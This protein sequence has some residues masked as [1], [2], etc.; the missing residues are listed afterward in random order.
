MWETLVTVWD[1]SQLDHAYSTRRAYRR[2]QGTIQ[3]ARPKIVT[4]PASQ[5]GI[6]T[7]MTRSEPGSTLEIH[8]LG[9]V[10]VLIDGRPLVVD[11]RKALAILVLL[12]V[13]ARPFARE[14]LA[15]LLWPESD[16]ESARGAL[17][18]TLSVLRA[19]LGGRWLA[20]DRSVV[21][22]N[23]GAGVDLRT[24]VAATPSGDAAALARAAGLA[25]GPFLAGF[26]LRDSAEFD[27]WRAAQAVAAE[28]AV[29]ALLDRLAAVAEAD[30]DLAGAAAAARR[31]VDLDP[32]DEPAQRRLISVL[33]RS[34]D[35]AGAIRQYRACVAL[36]ERELGVAPLPDTTQ[37]YEAIRDGRVGVAS[38][39]AAP[40]LGPESPDV[41]VDR[42]VAAVRQPSAPPV[43]ARLPMIGRDA[44]LASVLAAHRAATH[45]GRIVLLAG[46]AGIGKTRL[47]EEA[48]AAVSAGGART[49]T[50]RAFASEDGIPYAPVVELLRSGL[51]E[52]DAAARLQGLDPGVLAELSRLVSLPPGLT[53]PAG[54]AR[55]PDALP[56]ARARLLD[57]IAAALEACVAGPM[58]GV[59]L[60]EDV[61]WLDDASRE[62]IAY[63]ARRLDGRAILL[64][65]AYRPEDL[66][67][68]SAAF[69]GT[70][71]DL[72]VTS[73]VSLGR[74]DRDDVAKLIEAAV[75]SG[76]APPDAERLADE[77]EGLPLYVVEAVA[78][79]PGTLADGPPRGVRALLRE[80]L[81]SV[82][83]APTQIMSAAA[84]IGRS[85]DLATVRVASGRSEDETVTALEELVRRGIVREVGQGGHGGFDFAH[86]R[87]R[88]AA[89]ERTSLAR[90]RL[91][92]R[93]VAE[94]LRADPAGRDDPGRLA[95]I[96]GHLRAAGL[97]A[98]AADAYRR[99]GTRARALYANEEA[100][101]DLQLALALGHPDVPRLQVEIGELLMVRGEYAGAV[102]ALEAS[103][104][105]ASPEGLPDIELRLGQVHAR[106]GDMVT[107]ASHL[108]AAI[109]GMPDPAGPASMVQLSQILV[110]RAAVAVRAG[111]PDRAV[112]AAERALALA[113]A[114]GDDRARGAA[115]RALG[116]VARDRGDLG[117]AR[118]ALRRS[119]E[120]ARAT[121]SATDDGAAIGARNALALVEAAAGDRG[122]A[123]AL[124]EDALVA[125]RRTGDRHLE[126][127]VENN[128]ADQ[129]HA[130]GRADEAM[131]H[132]KRAVTLFAEVGGRPGEL[133]PEIWK[134]VAW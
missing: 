99:A 13:E 101:A 126:A 87:L 105:L 128:L 18:R 124:L 17:R 15:A 7:A 26:S 75:A 14:E 114:S 43:A 93:R 92:H 89:Y 45:D 58:P 52:A 53:G 46:E 110:E 6:V 65:L 37:L 2:A 84:A 67:E 55:A 19:A 64:V 131:E 122:A 48:I 32:I 120:L 63:L 116:L 68:R 20:V 24:L 95:T 47:A 134:L 54:G 60:V 59:V 86:A 83:E 117:T 5:P 109:D 36:L 118:A 66:D 80:R 44:A 62:A 51:R 97:E 104:A 16:D 9:P 76:A 30:G 119:L 112:A 27:D 74:L 108:D 111:D 39:A 115:H 102:A 12:A 113:E 10:E 98:E 123:I 78:A 88:E 42:S 38:P 107:A 103:A 35:R 8:V 85:F 50:A 132:L 121:P 77:S 94:A 106:R 130:V 61:Q 28:H 79:G 1:A 23:S 72:A 33:A 4:A 125:C 90:R 91:L 70:I 100:L 133:E 21:A 22:L 73:S 29:A 69:V 96:A 57:A 71:E 31:Q 49:L 34:G 56:A 82:G 11:T 81:T 3:R 127:A 129:L 40:A 25:R 41:A